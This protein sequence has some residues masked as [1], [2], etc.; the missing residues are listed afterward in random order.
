MVRPVT[1]G[2][3][4]VELIDR[5]K[6]V[7]PELITRLATIDGCPDVVLPREWRLTHS[8]LAEKSINQM[9]IINVHISQVA[10]E[11]AGTCFSASMQI[12][13]TGFVR[14]LN[15]HHTT[16]LA[17]IYGTA[18]AMGLQVCGGGLIEAVNVAGMVT[19]TVTQGERTLGEVDVLA[20][21][22]IPNFMPGQAGVHTFLS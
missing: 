6:P 1:T 14:G 10:V 12:T 15:W 22:S 5:L 13:V 8:P 16:R 21:L 19:D 4:V 2:M 17:G 20:D 11:R 18:I 9:P 3:V 7:L